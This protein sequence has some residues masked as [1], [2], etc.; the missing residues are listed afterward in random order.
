MTDALPPE[1]ARHLLGQI[2][3][4]LDLASRTGDDARREFAMTRL[5]SSLPDYVEVLS[6][7]EI[8][9]ITGVPSGELRAL[10]R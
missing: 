6:L 8:S 5:A 10:L 4:D 7:G 9:R 2:R 3:E 1:S